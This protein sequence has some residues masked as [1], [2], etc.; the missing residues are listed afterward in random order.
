[1]DEEEEKKKNE[2]ARRRYI[3]E[4]YGSKTQQDLLITMGYDNREKR[5]GQCKHFDQYCC[6]LNVIPIRVKEHAVCDFFKYKQ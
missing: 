2:D 4:N 6:T 3:A 1:M 5:C